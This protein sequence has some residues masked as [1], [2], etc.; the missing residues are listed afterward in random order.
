[1]PRP[2]AGTFGD[3]GVLVVPTGRG[4]SFLGP[5]GETAWEREWSELVGGCLLC[6]GEG[7]S[8]DGDGLL[9]SFTTEGPTRGGA[10]AR[11]DV[12]GVLDF[13]VDGFAF[14]HDAVR[15]PSDDTI[16]IPEVNGSTASWIAGDGSSAEVLRELGPDTPDW[17][18]QL[19]NGAERFD[20]GG[21]RYVLFSH[22]GLP[23]RPTGTAAPEHSTGLLS[24]WDITTPSPARVWVYP[25]EGNLDVPHGA[26]FRYFRDQWWLLY[27]HTRGADG[28][29]TVGLAVTDDPTRP[30]AYVA[31]LLP[32][33][34]GAPLDFLRGVE[35]TADG[36]LWLVDSGVGN[37]VGT[38]TPTG[39]LLR[40]TFPDLAPRGASGAVD[41]DQVFVDQGVEVLT[42]GL[43]NPFEGWLW[44]PTFGY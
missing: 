19:P 39:R 20:F 24:L 9:L 5:E 28:G 43:D 30:P 8:A 31:D 38:M 21:R 2:D 3:R 7:A 26:V 34:P 15:D 29:S 32:T 36:T 33:G 16:V 10:V 25:P 35:L 13:R 23:P 6:G 37:G 42:G 1:M 41:R 18:G 4:L 44:T 22:R 11:L 40:A 14:P 12:D 27:A 17:P